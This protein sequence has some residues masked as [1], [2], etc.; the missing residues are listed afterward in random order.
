M[1]EEEN[2]VRFTTKVLSRG[3]IGIERHIGS[4]EFSICS[5]EKKSILGLSYYAYKGF[6]RQILPL[7][8]HLRL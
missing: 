1:D 6:S 4:K 5:L 2:W 3:K 8:R 7:F